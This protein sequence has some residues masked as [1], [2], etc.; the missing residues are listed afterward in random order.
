MRDESRKRK[1]VLSIIG[2][3]GEIPEKTYQAAFLLGKL[4][5]DEGFR[6]ATGGLAG[7]MEAASR[8]AHQSAQWQDGCVVGILPTY[9]AQ[10]ANP[11]VD[12]AIPTGL[13][14]ARNMLV[15]ATADVVIAVSGGSGTLSEMALAWQMGKPVIALQTLGGWAN[16]LAGRQLD[17]RRQGKILS[18][19][20]PQEAIEF[21]KKQL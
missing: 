7:V 11:W 3:G 8:G 6:I 4:A 16:E 21:A 10:S 13:H 17:T 12:I 20:T 14:L 2:N 18:A 9:D 1:P 5:I 15:V 19:K